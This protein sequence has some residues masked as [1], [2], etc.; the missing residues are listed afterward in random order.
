MIY[1]QNKT[2]YL[3]DAE[4]H[5]VEAMADKIRPAD[6]AELWAAKK[7]DG[8]KA[9]DLS[10]KHSH[11]A[12]TLVHQDAPVAMMGV[13]RETLLSGG[14]IWMLATPTFE[15]IKFP[16]ARYCRRV[17]GSWLDYY[18]YLENFVDARNQVSI[19][20]LKWCG[21]TIEQAQPYGVMGLPFHH[22]Y[23]AKGG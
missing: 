5:H 21:F 13:A 18:G 19:D 8:R 2:A 4:I 16:F 23:L 20:W 10:Y 1:I 15:E 11:T 9:L 12:L 7:Y 3:A 17:I 22:F 14:L 6:L